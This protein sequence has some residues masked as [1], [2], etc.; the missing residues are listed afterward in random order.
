MAAPR[1][2]PRRVPRPPGARP[3]R[4]GRGVRGRQP[5]GRARAAYRCGLVATSPGPLRTTSGRH[6]VA[7]EAIADGRRARRHAHG[8]RAATAPT[9]RSPTRTSSATSPA[10]RATPA[11]SRAS[12]PAPSCSPRPACSTGAAPPPTGG[13]ATCSRRRFPEVQVEPD[14]IFVRDGNVF[15][16]AGVTAGHGPRARARRGRPRPRRRPGH[17]PPPGAVPAP[18]GQP[19]AVQRPARRPRPPSA[20]GSARRSTSSTEHPEGDCSVAAPRRRRRS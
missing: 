6:G 19:V 7:D 20:T 15:T 14:P 12:A 18:P 4:P 2:R 16:S 10:S 5:G 8:R 9:A 11:G 1:R 13:P 3:H 17:R